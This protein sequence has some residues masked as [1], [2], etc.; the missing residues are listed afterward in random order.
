MNHKATKSK[1]NTG[2]TV[3]DRSAEQTIGGHKAPP[4]PT[5]TNPDPDA[6]LNTETYKTQSPKGPQHRQSENTKIKSITMTNKDEHSWQLPMCKD[7]W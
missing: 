5:N 4:R 7:K 1:T 3:L 6:T 2:T